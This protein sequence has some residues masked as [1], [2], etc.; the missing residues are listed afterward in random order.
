MT[1]KII[2]KAN[3][4]IK[5]LAKE[6]IETIFQDFDSKPFRMQTVRLQEIEKLKPV[7]VRRTSNRI[8]N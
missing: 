5:P 7:V 8:Q 4:S 2:T 1:Y 6:L 3:Q